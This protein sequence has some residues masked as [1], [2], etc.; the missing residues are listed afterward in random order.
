[1]TNLVPENL[2]Y[3]SPHEREIVKVTRK[4]SQTLGTHLAND[5]NT[6]IRM[7]LMRDNEVTTEDVEL[8]EKTFRPDIG[9]LKGKVKRSRPLPIQSQAIDMSRGLLS[10]H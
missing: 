4:A 2:S 6:V 1:M 10:L 7:N 5:F 3:L 9:E 8:A